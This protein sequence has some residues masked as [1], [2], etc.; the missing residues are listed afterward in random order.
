[1]LRSLRSRLIASYVIL[2]AVCLVIVGVILSI[3]LLQRAAYARLRAAVVPT[4]LFVRNLQQRGFSPPEIVQ[5][6]DE[7]VQSQGLDILILSRQGEV[8]AATDEAWLGSSVP[9]RKIVTSRERDIIE[10]QITSPG[11]TRLYFVAWPM[12]RPADEGGDSTS[13]LVALVTTPWRGIR[14]V[15]VDLTT[16]FAMASLLAFAISL[17][18][19]VLIARS[20][21]RPLQQ[22]TAATE[23][24]ARGNY[25]LTLN[26]TSPTEVRR[27]AASFN[28]MARQVKA[29]RQAQR[30]FVTNV[31]HELKTPLTSI[32]GY[33]QAI[34]D[35][36]ARGEE[37][38]RRAAGIVH[39]EAE[40]MRR[41]VEGLLDLARIESGQVVM[42]QEPVDLRQ[43]LG[44]GVDKMALRAQEGGITLSLNVPDLLSVL[45]DGDRLAQVT[46]NLLDNALKHTPS[47]G[48]VTVEA[49]EIHDAQALRTIEPALA[50]AVSLPAV[51]MTVS[52]TG[53]GIPPEEL[54]RI[55]ERF[56]QVDKSRT[57]G[58]AGVGLGL[59]IVQ[60][61]VAAH[62]GRV[63]VQSV[64][65]VGTKFIVA[66]PASGRET[67]YVKH[68]GGD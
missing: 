68:A 38:V 30:D 52:D 24:I 46:T 31:S 28:S 47:G 63:A 27:L 5:R 33:S 37:A 39:D 66:L 59:A 13:A 45:G 26:I 11:G 51:I 64:V 18:L 50:S 21:S 3:S 2:I 20:I 35:G 34:L 43:V 49:Q 62:G 16:S 8:L 19:A 67:T 7:Q 23:E 44:D 53:C 32:Q 61:I 36:T 14:A 15:I 57:G 6:M 55:F 1:M 12:R 29:S 54:P 9:L 56:Y 48:R 4:A 22:V 40:R 60:E 17:I 42:A 65:G 10:G 58:K 25:D 41:L